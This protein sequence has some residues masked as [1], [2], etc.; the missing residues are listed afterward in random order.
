[1]VNL[2]FIF[3]KTRTYSSSSNFHIKSSVEYKLKQY[4]NVP[5]DRFLLPQI[6]NISSRANL[7]DEKGLFLNKFN[8]FEFNNKN[9][10]K[11]KY[12]KKACIYL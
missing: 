8:K 12:L 7:K 2:I 4:N 10:L 5:K 6:N 1:M 9:I 11:Q 3:S